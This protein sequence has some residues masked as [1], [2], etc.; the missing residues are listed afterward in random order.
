MLNKSKNKMNNVKHGKHTLSERSK[1][2][3]IQVLQYRKCNEQTSLRHSIN[4]E[5]K[6]IKVNNRFISTLR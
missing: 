2:A 4:I 6:I 5:T 1:S 3:H